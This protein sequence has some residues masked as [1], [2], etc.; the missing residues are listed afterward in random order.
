MKYIFSLIGVNIEKID[1][2]YGI[3]IVPA[4]IQESL[5]EMEI[6]E[7]V[8]KIEEITTRKK[9]EVVSFLDESKQLRKCTVS[10]IDINNSCSNDVT[11]YKCFW[12]KEYLPEGIVP[13]RC[14]IR[15][16]PDRAIKTYHSEISKEK[17]TISEPV[18]EKR[19]SDLK[20][21]K[22]KRISIKNQAYYE[23]DGIFCSF[24]CCM[25]FI[26]DTE[27]KRN[28]LYKQSASLLLKIYNEMV[29]L[30]EEEV[31]EISPASHWRNLI[32][33][34][35]QLTIAK[36]RE[37]FNKVVYIDHGNISFVSMGRLFE[38]QIKF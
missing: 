22:D 5:S 33:F 36:F 31:K 16:I 23:S 17:Y 18:T 20:Q 14:P 10:M 15:Y 35:G 27:Q 37:S 26:N 3:N 29:S 2:K 12:D 38:E 25:A 11:K 1:Q 32:E 7:N 9:P 30:N 6:P 28:P 34:G 21:K 13:V 4:N 24:N 19:V 8:T